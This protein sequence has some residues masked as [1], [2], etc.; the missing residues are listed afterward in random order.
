MKH[1]YLYLPLLTL[2]LAACETSLLDRAGTSELLQAQKL[3]VRDADQQRIYNGYLKAYQSNDPVVKSYAAYDLAQI[4][5]KRENYHAA[6][7][8]MEAAFASGYKGSQVSLAKLYL[9]HAPTENN[10]KKAF[11]ILNQNKAD[12]I[13]ANLVLAEYAIEKKAY[14]H[15]ITDVSRAAALVNNA[16]ELDNSYNL[17]IAKIFSAIPGKKNE[18]LHWYERESSATGSLRA[19]YAIAAIQME[20][21]EGSEEFA[22]G[23][24]RM[25]DVFEAGYEPATLKLASYHSRAQDYKK[26]LTLYHFLEEQGDSTGD[27][28]LRLSKLYNK[29]DGAQNA[30]LS[31]KW[32]NTSIEK[33]NNEAERELTTRQKRAA[34]KAAAKQQREA[35]RKSK[36]AKKSTRLEPA[37]EIMKRNT[38]LAQKGEALALFKSSV[39]YKPKLRTMLMIDS[40]NDKAKPRYASSYR[41]ASKE[42]LYNAAKFHQKQFGRLHPD[43]LYRQWKI[44]ADHG[45]DEAMLRVA[46]YYANVKSDQKSADTWYEK[47]ATDG[48]SEAMLYFAHKYSIQS[49]TESKQKSVAWYEKAAKAGS[50][51]AQYHTGM[52]YARGIGVN[53]D[54]EQATFWLEKAQKNGYNVSSDITSL[55]K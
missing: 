3:E 46:D 29:L 32:L 44:I 1:R 53:K 45:S 37:Y 30:M 48:N 6:I 41:N 52:A 22:K 18:A 14:D 43:M 31:N 9:R 49:D 38:P 42:E 23:Y 26:A 13:K 11:R 8:Y 10:I 33:Y 7:F 5:Q 55:L 25:T 27:Y 39:A 54:D 21:P 40:W 51:V 15:A 12:S 20:A 35:S 28:A 2:S 24:T 4:E 19:A 36:H 34:L 17:T 16:P 47:A 50:A